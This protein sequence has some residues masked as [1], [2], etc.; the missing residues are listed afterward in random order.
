MLH[1]LLRNVVLSHFFVYGSL[2]MLGN[3]FLFILFHTKLRKLVFLV[4]IEDE[5]RFFRG[6]ICIFDWDFLFAHNKN[7][8]FAALFGIQIVLLRM[9][10]IHKMP[11]VAVV[12]IL[13][14]DVLHRIGL[15][16]CSELP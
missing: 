8:S 11:V 5:D 15:V 6:L 14:K 10:Q 13:G 16:D 3:Y 7:V 1:F 12:A 4:A 2:H 9:D